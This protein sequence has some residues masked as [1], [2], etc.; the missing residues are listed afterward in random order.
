MSDERREDVDVNDHSP[1][2]GMEY[3]G[4]P[5]LDLNRDKLLSLVAHLSEQ[6]DHLEERQMSP[7]QQ[8]DAIDDG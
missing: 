1:L 6:I 4:K 2:E 5:V 8:A 3:F 7:E